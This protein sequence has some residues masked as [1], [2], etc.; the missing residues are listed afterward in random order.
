M[1]T[2]TTLMAAT[3]FSLTAATAAADKLVV[4]TDTAFVPF[5][6]AQDGEYVGFDIDMWTMIAEELELEFE[7]RPMDFNGIIPG[8]QTGQL[9]VALAGITIREDRAEVIDFSDGYYESGFRIMVPID[10]DIESAEDLAGKML[11]VRTGTSAADYAREN[12]TDTELRQFPN[13]DNAYLELRTGRVDAAMHDTPNVLYY[14]ATAGD[15]QVK[16]VG[17]QMMAHEYG[18]AFPK[19][20]ELVEPVNQALAAMREDGRYDEIYA[21]W[22]GESPNE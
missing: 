9:D 6:F 21:K 17:E 7:L 10:S 18:I 14:I 12:F 22:F 15:G 20:S 8:L 11:A 2:L 5:E 1:K 16:A 13:I 19:G 4:A 3:A